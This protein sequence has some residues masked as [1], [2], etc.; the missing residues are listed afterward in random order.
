LVRPQ[1][2]VS[3]RETCRRRAKGDFVS[4]G[5]QRKEREKDERRG[6]GEGREEREVGKGAGVKEQRRKEQ[7]GTPA[8]VQYATAEVGARLESGRRRV[9]AKGSPEQAPGLLA[10][11]E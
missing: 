5:G 8:P 2:K 1:R 4:A 10:K 6:E 9:D 3:R 11:H 7:V